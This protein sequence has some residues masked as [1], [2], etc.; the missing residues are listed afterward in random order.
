MMCTQPCTWIYSEVD[1][2]CRSSDIGTPMV[3]IDRVFLI[4][5]ELE[6]LVMDSA[7]EVLVPVLLSGVKICFDHLYVRVQLLEI[8]VD[9]P[10]LVDLDELA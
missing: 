3:F 2:R 4:H 1:F 6:E 10:L 8:G 7:F 5:I 9:Q